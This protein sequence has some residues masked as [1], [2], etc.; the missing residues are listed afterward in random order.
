MQSG[1]FTNPEKETPENMSY[2]KELDQVKAWMDIRIQLYEDFLFTGTRRYSLPTFADFI[3]CDMDKPSWMEHKYLSADSLIPDYRG[4][5]EC[6]AG[7]IAYRG[8]NSHC[9]T[10]YFTRSN[11]FGRWTVNATNFEKQINENME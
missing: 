10:R 5:V 7:S 1:T 9:G 8:L 2:D 11:I 4:G 3:K 6:E